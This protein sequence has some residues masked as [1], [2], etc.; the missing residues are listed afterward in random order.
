MERALARVTTRIIAAS[1]SEAVLFRRRRL[2]PAAKVCMIRNGIEVDPP[3]TNAPD[4]RAIVGAPHDAPLVGTTARLVSQK[5]PERFVA[6]AATVSR[7][8]PDAHFVLIGDGPLRS[9]V[10]AEMARH[11][12]DRLHHVPDLPDAHGVLPQLDVFVSASRFEGGPYAPLEAMRAAVPVVLTDVV[13]NHDLVE[14]GRSG[15]LVAED[16]LAVMADIVATLLEDENRRRTVGRSGQSRARAS[17]D[18]TAMGQ[19]LAAVYGALVAQ[20]PHRR[21]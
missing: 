17:F 19:A 4:L 3:A 20:P 5:A 21:R 6:L 10:E 1:E 15:F 18:V 12:V 7:R 16:D 8:V 2:A 14:H 11:A 13:G 9:T